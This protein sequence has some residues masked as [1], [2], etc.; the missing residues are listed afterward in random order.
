MNPV[1]RRASRYKRLAL[2]YVREERT[3]R[4]EFGD[5]VGRRIRFAS[6]IKC[7][8]RSLDDNRLPPGLVRD[9]RRRLLLRVLAL[10]PVDDQP[11]DLAGQCAS[12]LVGCQVP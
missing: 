9:G 6:G 1:L 3:D 10:V 8:R 12:N 2:L 5:V 4:I 7:H 11:F